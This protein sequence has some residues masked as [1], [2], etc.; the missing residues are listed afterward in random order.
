MSKDADALPE[1]ER[2]DDAE[3]KHA[4]FGELRT[5]TIELLGNPDAAFHAGFRAGAVWQ[6]NRSIES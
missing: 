3:I 1:S 6:H 4:W 5:R 2:P